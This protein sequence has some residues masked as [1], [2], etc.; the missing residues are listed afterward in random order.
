VVVA[1]IL[2]NV[3]S[4]II[5]GALLLQNS[6]KPYRPSYYPQDVAWIGLLL[7]ILFFIEFLVE[8]YLLKREEKEDEPTDLEAMSD[9]I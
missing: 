6:N 4:F 9:K 5:A 8:L 2:L 7:L 1:F 3:I